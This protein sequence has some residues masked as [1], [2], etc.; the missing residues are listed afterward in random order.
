MDNMEKVEQAKNKLMEAAL[1]L[2][3][4]NK[5][6]LIAQGSNTVT[7]RVISTNPKEQIQIKN[8]KQC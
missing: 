7:T 5:K 2:L 6:I 3:G 8:I 4:S 1:E